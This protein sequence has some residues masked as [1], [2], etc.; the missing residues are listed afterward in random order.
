MKSSPLYKEGPESHTVGR[1]YRPNSR[2]HSCNWCL[3]SVVLCKLG[4][5]LSGKGLKTCSDDAKKCSLEH[6]GTL[7][8]SWA[9][10]WCFLSGLWCSAW[11][12]HVPAGDCQ[13][14]FSLTRACE[15]SV[16]QGLAHIQQTTAQPNNN[17]LILTAQSHPD[18]SHDH[19][20]I[21]EDSE[22]H[23]NAK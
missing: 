3:Y 2:G 21:S 19:F 18:T 14:R 7:S 20:Q 5:R 8:H 17:S 12:L 23:L 22:E 9:G 6:K 4:Q 15:G 16:W 11:D 13:G 1:K 10:W